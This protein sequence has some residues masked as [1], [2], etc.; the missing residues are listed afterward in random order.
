MYYCIP[1][2]DFIP[3]DSG[4]TLRFR[5]TEIKKLLK[6][7]RA[8]GIEIEIM[9]RRGLA[10]FFYRYRYRFGI[11][12]GIVFA[13][14]LVFLS[15]NFIWDID[16]VGNENLTS[17][18]IRSLLS[19]YGFSV[20][21]YIPSI[22]TDRIE[23]KILIDTENI[24]WMSIN[25][26][27][28]VA[29]VQVR[30]YKMAEKTESNTKPANLVASKSG[31]VE[32]VRIYRGNVVVS[33][34]KFV[35]KGDLLVSGLFDSNR[36]GFRYTRASGQVLAR[37]TSEFF[38]EIPYEYEGIV[39]TGE[40][41]YDKYLNFFNFSI[42]ISKNYG[43]EGALYDKIDIVENCSFPDGV[44]T[45]FEIRTV[46]YLEYENKVLTRSVDEAENLAYFELARRLGELAEDSVI[47]RKTVT[48]SIRDDRFSLYCVIVA[49]ED[50]A[51]VSEFEVELSEE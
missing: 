48:P 26:K 32:E 49:I 25:I 33:S 38:I 29:E 23:N 2:P 51:S 4:L 44:P 40:E 20:G 6:E 16:V 46:R 11:F 1:Y 35:E 24:S 10:T 41:Y 8:R 50:I 42:K 37:T 31:V 9:E 3:T 27:G 18:E 12:L 34:G 43:K 39:Y 19:D 47:I 30:E 7:A 45:P 22:N 36:V 28:N 15:R 5:T 14:A 17:S 13:A 21:S